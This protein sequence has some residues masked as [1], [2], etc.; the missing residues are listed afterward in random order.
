AEALDDTR[1]LMPLRLREGGVG[2][3]AQV[4]VQIGAAD[5]YRFDAHQRL[6]GTRYRLCDLPNLHPARR[7]GNRCFHKWPSLL[8]GHTMRP[9]VL[10]SS[11]QWIGGAARQPAEDWSDRIPG[12]ASSIRDSVEACQAPVG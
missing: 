2:M 11:V 4:Q 6:I 1:K 10:L 8:L 9:T 3:V 5:T 7:R 12:F